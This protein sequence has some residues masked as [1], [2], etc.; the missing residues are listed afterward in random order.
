MT[1]AEWLTCDDPD[2]MLDF[3]HE[4]G[5]ARSRSGQRRFRLFACSC[6]RCVWHLVGAVAREAIEA[7]EGYADGTIKNKQRKESETRVQ[8]VYQSV[9]FPDRPDE[10]E[11]ATTGLAVWAVQS[12]HVHQIASLTARQACRVMELEQSGGRLV[13]PGE[14][15]QNGRRHQAALLRDL[16]GPFP[17]RPVDIDPAWLMWHQRTIPKIAQGIYDD[18]TFDRLPVLADALED[19]GCDQVE[20]LAHLRGPG[21]HVRGCWVIDLL[22][23]K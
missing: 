6:C 5:A 16:F 12:P 15:T 10:L 23:G 22:L 17:L 2:R 13:P 8:E 7:A 4:Q 1:E 9:S 3:L 21:P 19:A 18:R 14:A 11:I 20:L